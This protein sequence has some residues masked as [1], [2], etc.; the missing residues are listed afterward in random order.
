MTLNAS[1]KRPQ[2]K[3]NNIYKGIQEKADGF[4]WYDTPPVPAVP[5]NL[6]GNESDATAID[7]ASPNSTR[8]STVVSLSSPIEISSTS[9]QE[10]VASVRNAPH[11]STNNATTREVIMAH[12]EYSPKPPSCRVT[13]TDAALAKPR[14]NPADA[15]SFKLEPPLTNASLTAGPS[16]SVTHRSETPMLAD[17][18]LADGS[19]SGPISTVKPAASGAQSALE[20]T[21]A[22]QEIARSK[23]SKGKGANQKKREKQAH[24]STASESSPSLPRPIP[25]IADRVP[26]SVSDN[27]S[28]RSEIANRAPHEDSKS[29]LI[30]SESTATLESKNPILSMKAGLRAEA[31]SLSS[32]CH[33]AFHS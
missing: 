20:H 32:L 9:H 17:G 6:G 15:T 13:P 31:V 10:L 7:R 23:K 28:S 16:V 5:P 2:L 33:S 25:S 1:V 4:D 11:T 29:D 27:T 19:I 22:P 21:G 12:T 3:V 18:P 8:S 26:I 14:S 30:P 24:V